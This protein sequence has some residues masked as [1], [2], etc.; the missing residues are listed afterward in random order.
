M[1]ADIK[2]FCLLP[3][4]V[5]AHAEVFLDGDTTGEHATAFGGDISPVGKSWWF[6]GIYAICCPDVGP[7]PPEPTHCETAFGRLGRGESYPGGQD[8]VFT[9]GPKSNPE[10]LQTLGL[11][12]NRWG[13]AI[14]LTAQGTYVGAIYAGAGLNNINKGDRV[15]SIRIH[16]NCDPVT[17]ASSVMLRYVLSA[18]YPTAKIGEVHIYASPDAPTT[19]APGQYGFIESFDADSKTR[20]YDTTITLPDDAL[21]DGGLWVIMHAVVCW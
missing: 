3:L 12:L 9:T 19:I 1:I 21:C 8:Y 4:F 17:G 16:W 2:D 20:L 13:W 5:V 7:P 11:S 18:L 15:G 14:N 6:Y 10:N